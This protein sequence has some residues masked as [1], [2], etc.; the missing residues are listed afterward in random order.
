MIY[1]ISHKRH[2]WV[3]RIIYY[4]AHRI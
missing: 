3:N 1:L 4:E 2:N